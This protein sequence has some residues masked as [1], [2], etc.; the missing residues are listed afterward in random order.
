MEEYAVALTCLTS[1]SEAR[2]TQKSALCSQQRDLL[3]TEITPALVRFG[4]AINAG[5]HPP[6]GSPPAVYCDRG[7]LAALVSPSATVYVLST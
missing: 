1:V 2:Q 7:L 6:Q 4:Q 5:R 3:R